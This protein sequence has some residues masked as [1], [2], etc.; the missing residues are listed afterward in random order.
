MWGDRPASRNCS[1]Q[2]RA[3]QIRAQHPQA[4]L[5]SW[6]DALGASEAFVTLP[7]VSIQVLRCFQARA[8]TALSG[9]MW[10]AGR[11]TGWQP[12]QWC[13]YLRVIF[14]SISDRPS[15]VCRQLRESGSGGRRGVGQ[16]A[17][18]SFIG[19]TWTGPHSCATPG[20][21]TH[22][23]A[24]CAAFTA[25]CGGRPRRAGPEQ[26]EWQSRG[27][28]ALPFRCPAC[29]GCGP[30]WPWPRLATVARAGGEL[31]SR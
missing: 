12:P 24:Y 29:G 6:W 18:H 16:Q 19:R 1:P 20:P 5:A 30:W 4:L 17:V 26:P 31:H 10:L 23:G 3:Q 7:C 27:L 9:S 22:P 2:Q 28:R 13:N 14:S 21:I 11:C 25:V 8:S 15:A